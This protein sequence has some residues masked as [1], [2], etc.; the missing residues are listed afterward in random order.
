MKV[1]RKPPDPLTIQER[2]RILRDLAE[3]CDIRIWAY[4]CFAFFT[5]MRPEELMA[6]RWSDIVWT[7]GIARVQRVRTFRGSEREG[8]KTNTVRDVDLVPMA[9]AALDAMKPFT[10]MRRRKDGEE[11]DIFEN[12]VTRQAWHD[13]R[14]QRDRYWAPS[15]GA[16]PTA[17]AT[18]TAPWH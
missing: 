4:F 6:L 8:T 15:D 14:S 1:V 9:L 18:P 12:P 7:S 13:E 10:Y 2:D 3:H 16:G 11:A 5:G 17:R